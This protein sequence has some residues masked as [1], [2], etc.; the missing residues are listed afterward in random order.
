[1]NL[2]GPFGVVGVSAP[3]VTPTTGLNLAWVV[4]GACLA[5]LAA[6]GVWL[7]YEQRGETPRPA[8]TRLMCLALAAVA[9]FCT[10]FAL[11]MG[12]VTGS[13]GGIGPLTGLGHEWIP[14]GE[15]W[16]ILGLEGFLLSGAA[17]D[18]G[19]YAL[20]L[21]QA[22]LLILATAIGVIPWADRAP[23]LVA[24]AYSVLFG[25][26]LYPLYA[27]WVWGGGWL[28]HLGQTQGLG[29]GLVDFAG[30]AVVNGAAGFAALGAF[31]ALRPAA[32]DDAQTSDGDS[33]VLTGLFLCAAGWIGLT[34]ASTFAMTDTRLAIAAANVFV[35]M[36]CAAAVGL[37]YTWFVAGEPQAAIGARAGL[38]GLVAVAAGAPF[39][40]AWAAAVVGGVAGLLA[41]FG[42]HLFGRLLRSQVGGAVVAVHGLAGAWGLLAVG[43]LADGRYGIGWNGIGEREYLA[44]AGQGVTGMFPATAAV[45]DANQL[46]AQA[47]GVVALFAFLVVTWLIVRLT[48]W[49]ARGQPPVDKRGSAPEYGSDGPGRTY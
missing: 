2:G 15:G 14:N 39:F 46:T 17:Y 8:G 20:F 13:Y 45:A 33:R 44:T 32:N 42:C 28:A 18:A 41:V 25:A 4:L 10:G 7:I 21:F 38:G 12:G 36:C 6:A 19:I 37:L 34:A 43:L 26:A 47:A 35:A 23:R 11:A 1:M 22:S 24:A 48:R 30:S 3:S 31:L 9:F 16:G 49:M 5:L 27:N 40:P 29:H